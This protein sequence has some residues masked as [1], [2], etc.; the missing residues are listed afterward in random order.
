MVARL[1]AADDGADGTFTADV[2]KILAAAERAGVAGYEISINYNGVPFQLIP[3]TASELKS[4]SKLELLS[5]NEA[6]YSKN[7]CRRLISKGQ[8]GWSLA[9]H[10]QKLFEL[11]CY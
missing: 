9:S 10:G 6:E 8:G 11:L 5:V 4:G 1:P 2:R 7:P 3:K